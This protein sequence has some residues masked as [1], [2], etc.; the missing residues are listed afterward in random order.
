MNL[1]TDPTVM[2][3]NASKLKGLFFFLMIRRPPRSTQAKTMGSA[4]K[5]DDNLAFVEQIDGLTQDLKNMA[6]H[7]DNAGVALDLQAKNYEATRDNNIA[8]V[9]QL[10]N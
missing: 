8:G 2:H 4:W 5:S 9:R 7:L 3:I 10:A 1:Q 6:T